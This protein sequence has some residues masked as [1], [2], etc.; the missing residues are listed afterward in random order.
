MTTVCLNTV[1]MHIKAS[2][3]A[4]GYETVITELSGSFL[5]DRSLHYIPIAIIHSA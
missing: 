5:Y 1:L 2:A 4:C 3:A